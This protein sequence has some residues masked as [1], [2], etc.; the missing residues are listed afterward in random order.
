[1]NLGTLITLLENTPKEYNV[2]F[3]FGYFFP[4]EL[5]SYRGDY[6]QL[7]MDYEDYDS[8]RTLFAA[9][10]KNNVE[11]NVLIEP[12]TVEWWIS[13]LKNAIGED[14][15]GYKGGWFEMDENTPIWAANH[16]D[17]TGAAIGRVVVCNTHDSVYLETVYA[18]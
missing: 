13:T 1:M 7:G 5:S 16:G 12:K 9:R 17:W 18:R 11:N 6:S 15:Q 8:A 2:M 3:A 4:T 10:E 14:F